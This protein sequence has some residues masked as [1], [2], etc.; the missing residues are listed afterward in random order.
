MPLRSIG[1][2]LAPAVMLIALA[3][4]RS[5]APSARPQSAPPPVVSATPLATPP[6]AAPAPTP[7]PSAR[8]ADPAASPA[9]QP[10]PGQ[11]E[12]AEPADLEA[13]DVAEEESEPQA[14]QKEALDLCQSASALLEEGKTEDA[15]AELDQAYQ[16]M[17]TLPLN[18]DDAYLQAKADIRRLVADLLQRAYKVPARPKAPPSWDLALPI[19]DNDHVRREIASF[20][21]IERDFFIE[22][23]RRSGLYRPAILAKLQAAGMP[24]QLSWLPLVE[25]WFK[26]RALS[27]AGALGMWQFIASTGQRYGLARDGWLDERMDPDKSADAAIAYLTELHSLFGD[28]PKVLAA[29]NCGEARVQRL[30]HS[31]EQYLDFWD[32]YER[33]PIETRRYVP[34]FI[35]ALLIV[36]N[37]GKYGITLPEPMSAPKDLT[38]VSISRPVELEKLDAALGLE[39]GTLAE[40]NPELRFGATPNRAYDLK[41]PSVVSERVAAAVAQIPEW[42]RPVPAFVTHRVRSGDTLG[43]IARRYGT[44]PGAIQRANA[45]RSASKLRIGQTLRIPVHER[46][47]RAPRR[48][49]R[50]AAQ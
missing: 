23:Y 41:I 17:L 49:H 30:S 50:K 42:T 44:T 40:M 20:T 25:S 7:T 10:S 13:A 35:A 6:P 47:P 3:G 27:R 37:P 34:R 38:S 29:Y 22:G 24:S 48:R 39:K 21:T 28:W 19:V 2:A 5:A 8:A 46:P 45:L 32:L 26:V 31:S 36:E 15:V 14:A 1:S 43:S 4:C 33:L 12:T 16:L 11:P 9:P 18:G